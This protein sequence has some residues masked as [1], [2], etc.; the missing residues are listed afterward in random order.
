LFKTP[1]LFLIYNRPD[2]TKQ[3]FE[4]IREVKPLHLYV[5]ADGPRADK[6][7]DNELYRRT[8]EVVSLIDWECDVKFLFRDE[9]LGCG[10]AVSEAITWFFEHVEEGV[11]LEDDCLPSI[12]FF[13]YCEVLLK[14][15]RYNNNIMHIGGTNFQTGFKRG[16]ADYYFSKIPHVWGWATWKN[17]WL[18]YIYSLERYSIEE[19]NEVVIR[20]TPNKIICD[21]WLNVFKSIA[22]N[23]IDTWDYQWQFAIWK[24]DA[25]S[26]T[27]QKN[28]ISNIGFSND[29]THTHDPLSPA[30]Q[31]EVF[32]FEI[33]YLLSKVVVNIKADLY[34]YKKIYEIHYPKSW[35][36]KKIYLKNKIKRIF[37]FVSPKSI[38]IH[39]IYL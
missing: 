29:A 31:N 13:K 4:K 12:T 26:I 39:T 36:Q 28:L 19:I 18:N 34:T 3:V 2:L 9:N 37:E 25:I 6:S 5:A 27:P 1:I 14:I 23:A 17:S 22:T 30:S 24:N 32:N 33:K 38:K 10:R 21:Y 35:F 16:N 7:G 8:R 15:Y 20:N 11:I